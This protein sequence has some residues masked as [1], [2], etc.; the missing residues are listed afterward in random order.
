MSDTSSLK[1]LYGVNTSAERFGRTEKKEVRAKTYF[2]RFESK[3]EAELNFYE[4]YVKAYRKF[5]NVKQSFENF[6]K[7]NNVQIDYFLDGDTHGLRHDMTITFSVDG[8]DFEME[9]NGVHPIYDLD[10]EIEDECAEDEDEDFEGEVP[11]P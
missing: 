8:F 1:T 3:E 6:Q 2:Y 11:S 7:E 4:A 10:A 9:M 5:K